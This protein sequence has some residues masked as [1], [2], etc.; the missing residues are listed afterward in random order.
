MK[1]TLSLHL[2][3]IV[4]GLGLLV[5]A[6]AAPGADGDCRFSQQRSWDAVLVLDLAGNRHEEGKQV[7]VQKR[8]R[9][10][11]PVERADLV[12]PFKAV[13]VVFRSCLEINRSSLRRV[14]TVSDGGRTAG[15]T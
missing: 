2:A 8:Q 9:R 12:M 15:E 5:A 13:H 1:N 14:E 3:L 11:E 4:L 10:I 7:P 6:H